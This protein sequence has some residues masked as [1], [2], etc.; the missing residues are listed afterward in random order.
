ALLEP[1][2]RFTRITANQPEEPQIPRNLARLAR[3]AA[4]K[5][6]GQCRAIAVEVL[7]YSVQAPDLIKTDLSNRRF[8]RGT[9]AVADDGLERSVAL[10]RRGELLGGVCADGFQHPVERSRALG[11]DANQ[12][13]LLDQ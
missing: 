8:R 7:S 5:Q 3:S 13:A 1:L 2:G 9:A 10:P 6:K 11:L 4:F 12:E